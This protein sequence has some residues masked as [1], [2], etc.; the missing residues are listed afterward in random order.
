[1]SITVS[2]CTRI[3]VQTVENALRCGLRLN[4]LRSAFKEEA[5]QG[6]SLTGDIIFIINPQIVPA[7]II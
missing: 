2:M 3:T 5:K 1:M 6:L 7:L 4:G